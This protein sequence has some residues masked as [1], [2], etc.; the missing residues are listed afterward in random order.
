M[1][2]KKRDL[3]PD[4]PSDADSSLQSLTSA[5]LSSSSDSDIDDVTLLS[6]NVPEFPAEDSIDDT[7]P[8]DALAAENPPVDYVII[9]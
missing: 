5:D 3:S 4:D 6:F 1:S 2:L 7:L 8:Q 9:P